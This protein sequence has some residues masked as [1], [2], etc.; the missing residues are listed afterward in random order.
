MKSHNLSCDLKRII[1]NKCDALGGIDV[2]GHEVSPTKLEWEKWRKVEQDLMQNIRDISDPLFGS[3]NV[4]LDDIS[5]MYPHESLQVVERLKTAISMLG[6]R[7]KENLIGNL[8]QKEYEVEKLIQN[9]MDKDWRKSKY[10]YSISYCKSC[11]TQACELK[12]K[13]LGETNQ[14][15]EYCSYF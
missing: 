12:G 14:M 15:C 5:K 7:L 10:L 11:I 13:F 8:I 3:E 9:F 1:A 6:E 2:F 4:P